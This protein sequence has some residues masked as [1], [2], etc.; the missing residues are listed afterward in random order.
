MVAT[1]PGDSVRQG[2]V[3]IVDAHLV[4]MMRIMVMMMVM[5]VRMMVMVFAIG[6][7]STGFGQDTETRTEQNT[8]CMIQNTCMV[9]FSP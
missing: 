4:M 8:E 2:A 9:T 6:P 5:M 1:E 7:C 3:H